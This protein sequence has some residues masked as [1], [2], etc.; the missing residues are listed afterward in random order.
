MFAAR[1]LENVCVCGCVCVGGEVGFV[2]ENVYN[3]KL[4][5]HGAMAASVLFL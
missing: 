4:F 2:W 1:V 5:C 3:V